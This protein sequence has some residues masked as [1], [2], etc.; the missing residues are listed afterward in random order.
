[1][2]VRIPLGQTFKWWICIFL[3]EPWIFIS[4]CIYKLYFVFTSV[5]LYPWHKH[6]QLVDEFSNRS[7]GVMVPRYLLFIN[8]YKPILW[9]N[10]DKLMLLWNKS[11]V[12]WIKRAFTV[13]EPNCYLCTPCV[14]FEKTQSLTYS[15]LFINWLLIVSASFYTFYLVQAIKMYRK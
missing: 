13:P 3:L 10:K 12:N 4:L 1:M 11:Y 5:V 7:I 9:N 2:R 8:L 15:R 14:F 6:K